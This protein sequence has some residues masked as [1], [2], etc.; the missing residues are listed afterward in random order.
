VGFS[1]LAMARRLI[2]LAVFL[3]VCQRR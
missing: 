3:L 1:A 2:W